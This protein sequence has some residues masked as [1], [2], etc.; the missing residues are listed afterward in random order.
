MCPALG[1]G[2][3]M[4]LLPN[5]SH[6]LEWSDRWQQP[7]FNIPPATVASVRAWSHNN[8]SNISAT[9][10]ID[11]ATSMAPKYEWAIEKWGGIGIWTADAAGVEER[12]SG[13][14]PGQA[15]WNAIPSPYL[16]VQLKSDDTEEEPRW[17]MGSFGTC[18]EIAWAH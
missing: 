3:L 5:S 2:Q 9:I 10:W 1:F 11:N 18:G 7:F 12:N 6:G 15:M 14:A 4:A 13:G 8:V 17:F 16:H